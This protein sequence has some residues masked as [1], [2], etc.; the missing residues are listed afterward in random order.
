MSLQCWKA[1]YVELQHTLASPHPSYLINGQFLV[2]I[3]HESFCVHAWNLIEYFGQ[4]TASYPTSD[5]TIR[6][7]MIKINNQVLTLPR[8][9]L[10][11]SVK[12]SKTKIEK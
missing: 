11:S 6:P 10:P 1:C 12:N 9:V 2:N 5:E 4:G 8:V 3:L 7:Y